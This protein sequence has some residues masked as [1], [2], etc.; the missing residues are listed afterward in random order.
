MKEERRQKLR[1][2]P[3]AHMEAAK[4]LGRLGGQ[5]SWRTEGF[6]EGHIFEGTTSRDMSLGG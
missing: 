5:R 6:R 1:S 3:K 2:R 4:T